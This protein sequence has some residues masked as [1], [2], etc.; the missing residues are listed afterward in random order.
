MRIEP[1]GDS[2]FYYIYIYINFLNYQIYNLYKIQYIQSL[3]CLKNNS[4]KM[5]A[6][7]CIHQPA[8][9][10]NTLCILSLKLVSIS[11]SLAAEDNHS[12]DFC[13]N[14]PLLLFLGLLPCI[15][16]WTCLL[17]IS[18]CEWNHTVCIFLRLAA[19]YRFRAW[20]VLVHLIEIHRIFCYLMYE[21]TMIYLSILCL[22]CFWVVSSSPNRQGCIEY[23]CTCLLGTRVRSVSGVCISLGMQ[24]T[25]RFS[26]DHHY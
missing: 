6:H 12:S 24:L 5:N 19:S 15:Y 3:C 14:H 10:Q 20:S 22:V 2:T 25:D 13:I 21:Y 4:L 16:C 9:G 18:G 11:L 26:S 23:P 17:K 1:T 8:Q 7:S